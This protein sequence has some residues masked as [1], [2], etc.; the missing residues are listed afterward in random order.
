MKVN[1][2]TK[3]RIPLLCLL[4]LT[5]VSP[6]LLYTDTLTTFSSSSSSSSSAARDQFIEEISTLAFNRDNRKLNL[7]PKVWG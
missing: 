1:T 2:K 7:L 6:L 5:V 4:F 3:L